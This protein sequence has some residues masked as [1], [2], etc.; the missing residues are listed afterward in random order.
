MTDTPAPTPPKPKQPPFTNCRIASFMSVD[1]LSSHPYKVIIVNQKGFM[2]SAPTFFGD[3]LTDTQARAQAYIDDAVVKFN[4][5]RD[6]SK[7]REKN[8]D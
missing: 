7:M 2:V 6:T 4:D 5:R 1:G 8:H 3:D